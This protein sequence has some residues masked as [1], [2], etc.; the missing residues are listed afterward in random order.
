MPPEQ[1]KSDSRNKRDKAAK[2]Q[3]GQQA[4][5]VNKPPGKLNA[6]GPR[7]AK[8]PAPI[9][10]P[11]SFSTEEDFTEFGRNPGYDE[12]EDPVV[13]AELNERA[14][15]AIHQSSRV[16]VT[17]LLKKA[18]DI[19][20]SF[21]TNALIISNV[22]VEVDIAT[23]RG[24]LVVIGKLMDCRIDLSQAARLQSEL[25]E[26]GMFVEHNPTTKWGWFT[27]GDPSELH[28]L[29]VVHDSGK[30]VPGVHNA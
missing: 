14:L 25:T 10:K 12:M 17:E 13:V 16:F 22:D 7:P 5:A 6:N 3:A 8:D 1:K 4:Q 28:D 27:S 15:E 2:Q 26:A 29:G 20:H 11:A 19:K 9:K 18:A 23:I 30:W 24:Y 21:R